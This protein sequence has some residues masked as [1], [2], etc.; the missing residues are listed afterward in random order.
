MQAAVSTTDVVG[1]FY[2]AHFSEPYFCSEDYV[3]KMDKILSALSTFLRLSECPQGFFLPG[4]G[5]GKT[6]LLY[7]LWKRCKNFNDKV[8]LMV[9]FDS[10]LPKLDSPRKE[11]STRVFYS[12]LRHLGDTSTWESFVGKKIYFDDIS[13]VYEC[14]LSWYTDNG[15]PVPCIY[16]FVDEIQ[17]AFDWDTLVS[18]LSELHCAR[19]NQ[20]NFFPLITTLSRRN[21]FADSR[22]QPGIASG[23]P[24]F[25]IPL[26]VIYEQFGVALIRSLCPQVDFQKLEFLDTSLVRAC[27]GHARSLVLAGSILNSLKLDENASVSKILENFIPKLCQRLIEFNQFCWLKNLQR[28]QE[29]SLII[30]ALL[31]HG[32]WGYPLSVVTY[33]GIQF[34]NHVVEKDDLYDRRYLFS[35]DGSLAL[36]PILCLSQLYF[37]GYEK[38]NCIMK[39]VYDYL[40]KLMSA[41]AKSTKNGNIFAGLHACWEWVTRTLYYHGISPSTSFVGD[42]KNISV[43]SHYM[44]VDPNKY[45]GFIGADTILDLQIFPS[46]LPNE[47]LPISR[48]LTTFLDFG[49]INLVCDLDATTANLKGFDL[50]TRLFKFI[51]E[52]N[53]LI[54]YLNIDVKFSFATTREEFETLAQHKILP[55]QYSF[56]IV[57]HLTGEERSS[58]HL[59]INR[60]HLKTLYGCLLDFVFNPLLG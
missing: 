40:S 51:Q 33:Y 53:C 19:D 12:F 10:Y 59:V 49:C 22:V 23:R 54:R 31:A 52:T 32:I 38:K 7:E 46:D 30:L 21:F 20:K 9:S 11:L 55:D 29:N 35:A 26:P 1:A 24:I 3:P 27:G 34:E 28:N 4:S 39:L 15:Q 25:W 44:A 57:A 6:R 58:C 48:N 2:S 42:K 14:I 13:S 41:D 37:L 16:V 43:V 47:P 18:L 8:S 5:S 50:S 36:V 56:G 45:V 60:G 17:R